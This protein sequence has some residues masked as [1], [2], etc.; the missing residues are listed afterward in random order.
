[1]EFRSLDG[2]ESEEYNGIA[3]VEM[4]EIFAEQDAVIVGTESFGKLYLTHLLLQALQSAAGT[5]GAQLAALILLP[6][7]TMCIMLQG[8]AGG[9]NQSYRS[10][11]PGECFI[12]HLGNNIWFT[13][14]QNRYH[15]GVLGNQGS[16][17]ILR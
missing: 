11:S 13:S 2:G 3:F 14:Q 10:Q 17:C 7:L 12:F 15:A 6:Y 4:S 16:P 1:M 9:P 5:T 8:G